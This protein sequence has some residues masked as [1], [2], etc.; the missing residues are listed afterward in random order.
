MTLLLLLCCPHFYKIGSSSH[1]NSI[2]FKRAKKSIKMKD[3][4]PEE[5]EAA[6][7]GNE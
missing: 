4:S 2:Y 3:D 5:A 1:F 7:K 6:A